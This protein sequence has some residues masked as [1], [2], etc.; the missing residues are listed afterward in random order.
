MPDYTYDA[1]ISYSHKD[2]KWGRRLQRRLETFRIPRDA[3]DGRPDGRR[4]R[5]FRD[6][7]D[8]AGAELRSSLHR[9]LDDSRYLIVICSPAAAASRWVDEEVRYFRSRRGGAAIVPFIVAGEPESEDPAL[10]CFPAALREGDADELLG[11][12]TLEIGRSKAFLKVVSVL[13]D[14]RLNRLVDR[15]K[16][17]RMRA[18]L[19]ILAA[20]GILSA[21]IGIL[22]WRDAVMRRRNRELIYDQ[23]GAAIVAI[24]QK[25]DLGQGEFETLRTSAEAGN[26]SSMLLL[27]DCLS[28]GVGTDRN[29]E[30]AFG[31]YLRAAEQGDPQGMVAV[32][33][34]FLNGTGTET[35][36]EAVFRWNERAAE[37]GE[38][39]GMVN[40]ASCYEE[41]Y[42]VP[43]NEK[44]AA[45]WYIRAAEA[46]NELGMYNA[47]RCCRDGVGMAADDGQAFLWMERLAETG[48]AFAMYNVAMM[49]QYGRGTEED[50]RQAYL[51]YRRAAEAGDPDGMR[52]TGWCIE[53]GYGVEDPALEWYVKAADAG[54]PLAAEEVRRRREKTSAGG[55]N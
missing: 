44:K 8:L 21:V 17:R 19:S 46:G 49:Y 6:Q 2:M 9:E 24:A 18:A 53:N 26:V 11:A 51:W 25:D 37:A 14:V 7:T 32:A 1:F 38:S 33:N 12:N 16:K 55:E 43:A 39:A 48:N 54:D 10:E 52:M 31:W 28:K 29:D 22:L 27:A 20:A 34:C 5:V 15:E 4:L 3:R 47:A 41:G 45:Y 13:L 23:Y 36:P 40:A 35:D 30:A 50:P 42:G